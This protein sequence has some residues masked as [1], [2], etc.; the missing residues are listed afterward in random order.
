[1]KHLDQRFLAPIL[2]SIMAAHGAACTAQT[3]EDVGALPRNVEVVGSTADALRALLPAE[4]AQTP[5]PAAPTDIVY[6]GT[7][8]YRALP[9][10]VA[11]KSD[12]KASVAA[13]VAGRQVL[14][15]ITDGG[16]AVFA[17]PSAGATAEQALTAQLNPGEYFLVFRDAERLATTVRV[18]LTIAPVLPPPPPPP[19]PPAGPSVL[20][21]PG[22]NGAPAHASYAI[23]NYGSCF[24]GSSGSTGAFVD[25]INVVQK[26]EC[27]GR[28][29][30]SGRG[31]RFEISAPCTVTQTS[32]RPGYSTMLVTDDV[33]KQM[34]QW[35]YIA[36]TDTYSASGFLSTPIIGP[37]SMSTAPSKDRNG[38]LVGAGRCVAEV[39]RNVVFTY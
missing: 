10:S 7:T 33:L 4:I 37:T 18:S 12:V 30:E 17:Q 1:M 28:L 21:P 9:F 34:S 2:A 11:V 19:P 15:W 24:V 23:T 27:D 14:A 29:V 6:D 16:T 31:M 25:G 5:A 36:A 32:N 20:L 22:K 39:L 26:Y 35:T 8:T 38:Y 13:T 3:S